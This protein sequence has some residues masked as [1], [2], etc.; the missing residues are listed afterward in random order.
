MSESEK[1][2][3]ISGTERSEDAMMLLALKMDSGTMSQR[4]RVASRG[5]KRQGNRFSSRASGRNAVL[6]V[7]F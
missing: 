4:V 3:L 6:S 7:L 5:Q 2:D 1:G